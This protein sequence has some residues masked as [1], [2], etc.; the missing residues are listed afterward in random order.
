MNLKQRKRK[1]KNMLPRVKNKYTGQIFY[2]RFFASMK[3][4][5][6]FWYTPTTEACDFCI[7]K[8]SDFNPIDKPWVKL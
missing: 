3:H 6:S 2:F 7:G 4:P 5:N 1:S 8:L